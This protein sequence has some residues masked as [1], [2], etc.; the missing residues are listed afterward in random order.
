MI[1][2]FVQNWNYEKT[3]QEAITHYMVMHL[4]HRILSKISIPD[5]ARESRDFGMESI[6][7][8]VW[9]EGS[10]DQVTIE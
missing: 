9:T 1:W 10:K 8:S 2:I 4:S 7:P 5:I 3:I 6:V